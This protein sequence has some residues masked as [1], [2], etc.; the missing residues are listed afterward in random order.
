MSV[1]GPEG[2]K[3]DGRGIRVKSRRARTASG[4]KGIPFPPPIAYPQSVMGNDLQADL[5]ELVTRRRILV[6][7][8]A[9]VSISATKNA[10]AS[11]WPG[12][13]TLGAAHCRK[14]NPR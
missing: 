2:G 5:R 12:L 9:G 4:Q 6:I 1:T 14:V 7:V 13:L 8:G 10:P 3:E 11:S